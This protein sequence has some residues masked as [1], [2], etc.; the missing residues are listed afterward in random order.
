MKI[1]HLLAA[2]LLVSSFANQAT[3][4]IRT[5]KNSHR[6]HIRTYSLHRGIP[7]AR[8]GFLNSYD[9]SANGPTSVS[10]GGT[11]WNGRSASEYGGGAP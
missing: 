5:D 2:L 9:D 4:H 3:A 7:V 1:T 11:M 10:A 6:A 8:S